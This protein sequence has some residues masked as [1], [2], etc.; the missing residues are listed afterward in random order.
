MKIRN[1]VKIGLFTLLAGIAL[2]IGINFLKGIDL[3]SKDSVYYTHFQQLGGVAT[4][5]PIKINGYKVGIVRTVD[6]GYTEGKG[7]GA[8]LTLA[9]D[10]KVKI[11]QGT[12]ITIKTS[13]LSGAELVLET[14]SLLGGY[15]SAGSTI[16]SLEISPDLLETAQRDLMPEMA[17]ILPKLT[18]SLEA[19][20]GILEHRSISAS[21]SEVETS[22]RELSKLMRLLNQSVHTLPQ[23]MK[24]V[25]G[26]TQS[27]ERSAQQVEAIKLDQLVRNLEETSSDLKAMTSALKDGQGTAGKLIYDPSLYNRLDSL[28]TSADAL[29]KDL[30]EHP[31]RYVHFSLF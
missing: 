2:Y 6:F 26:I 31:K 11:P 8:Q 9:I 4:A 5:T 24:N 12:I 25:E 10:P 13:L 15:I 18:E 27:L 7:Y 22:S 21:L 14:D 30:K 19:L 23:T 20:N 28:A 3:F 16:P 1:E 17:R 29:M